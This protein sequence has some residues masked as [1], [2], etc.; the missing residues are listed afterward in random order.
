[1]KVVLA[2]KYP[3][4]TF[5]TLKELLPESQFE[6]EAV[7]TPEAYET[8]TDAEIMILRIFKAPAEVIE[9]NKN[10]KMIDVYKRQDAERVEGLPQGGAGLRDR[11]VSRKLSAPPASRA[12]GAPL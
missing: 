7:D 5:E 10:L 8:M 4:R 9:R 3:A 2:G 11:A 12:E 6:L 1:M